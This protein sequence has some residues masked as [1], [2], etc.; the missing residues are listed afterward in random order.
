MEQ[1]FKSIVSSALKNDADYLVSLARKVISKYSTLI[2]N[3]FE[4]DFDSVNDFLTKSSTKF[5]EIEREKKAKAEKNRT[6]P[7]TKFIIPTDTNKC[8]TELYNLIVVP[9]K[10]IK[11]KKI[12]QKIYWMLVNDF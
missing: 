10:T 3:L 2:W 8:I 6:T 12:Y 1:L 4:K 5:L 7:K 9:L 11:K